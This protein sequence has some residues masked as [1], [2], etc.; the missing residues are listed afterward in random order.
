M[1]L[2][3]PFFPKKHYKSTKPSFQTV[4]AEFCYLVLI[5]GEFNHSWSLIC[6]SLV[7]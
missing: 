1:N 2:P 6:V 5:G 4:L 7:A 3:L